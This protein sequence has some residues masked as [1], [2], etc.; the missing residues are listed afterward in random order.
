[1]LMPI[2]M[3]IAVLTAVSA[4]DQAGDQTGGQMQRPGR[5]E[6]SPFV[7]SQYPS[8]L[9]ELDLSPSDVL[10]AAL[11]IEDR[12]AKVTY[13]PFLYGIVNYKDVLSETRFTLS[14]ANG[15]T[16]LGVAT[17]YN[18]ASPRGGRAK[19]IWEKPPAPEA[20]PLGYPRFLE[21]R[22]N[23]TSSKISAVQRQIQG[24]IGKSGSEAELEQ[25]LTELTR[26]TN[27]AAAL[28]AEAARVNAEYSRKETA[29]IMSLYEELL[30]VS[31]PVVSGS[32]TT[33][34]FGN[35]G[36]T[37]V[38]ADADGL[39]DT[40]YQVKGR[41][42]SLNADVPF[43][44]HITIKAE[45][46]NEPPRRYWRWLQFSGA[47]TT[48]WQRASQE[49]GTKFA[50]LFGFGLTGGGIVKILNPDYESTDDYRNEF[51]IPSISIGASY[52]RKMCTSS[53]KALCPDRIEAQSAFT[54][55]LDFKITKIAQFRV[56]VPIKFTKNVA[57][58]NTKDLGIV[59][60]Y[61]FQLGAP[62]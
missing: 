39:N 41:A 37:D 57:K 58:Q 14:Q 26:L 11:S 44:R 35:L 1:M 51:F 5:V 50:R 17:S 36:G 3:L 28:R 20:A 22:A 62:K 12:G 8:L 25:Q 21:R 31:R 45:D 61:A 52:E 6:T 38:D 13:N 48:D 59:T 46:Q 56:G 23:A 7:R 55:F 2:A 27:D 32:F 29:K 30:K 49:D 4:G 42:L 47:I 53:D 60:V 34:F 19:T 43:R 33:S 54:P 24:L 10:E 40:R 9:R 15:I 18:P 16:T